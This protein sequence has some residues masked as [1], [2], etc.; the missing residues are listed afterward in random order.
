MRGFYLEEKFWC[1]DWRI[2]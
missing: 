1:V 2:S